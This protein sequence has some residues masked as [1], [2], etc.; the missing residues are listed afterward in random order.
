V[1]SQEV[2]IIS[3]AVRW[4]AKGELFKREGD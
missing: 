2:R 4:I 3:K 1:R